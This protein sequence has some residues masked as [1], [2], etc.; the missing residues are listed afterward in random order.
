MIDWN[1]EIDWRKRHKNLVVEKV[2]ASRSEG[3]KGLFADESEW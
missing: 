3:I 2:V 1:E